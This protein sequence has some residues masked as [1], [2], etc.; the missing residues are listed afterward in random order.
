MVKRTITEVICPAFFEFDKIADNLNDVYS[1]LNL[2]Y[3]FLT[4]QGLK[5]LNFY[6]VF[7]N[8]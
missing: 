5:L 7:S 2:R 8:Q 4:D 6:E 1:A 3:G